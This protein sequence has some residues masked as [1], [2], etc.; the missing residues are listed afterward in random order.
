MRKHRIDYEEEVRQ[1]AQYYLKNPGTIRSLC[2]DLNIGKSAMHYRLHMSQF[3]CPELWPQILKKFE[4]NLEEGHSKGG[5]TSMRKMWESH[6]EY[7]STR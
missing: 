4:S 7:L 6:R 1:A 2:R 5:K 3:Y